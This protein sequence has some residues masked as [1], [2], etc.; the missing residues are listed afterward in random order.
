MRRDEEATYPKGTRLMEE[1]EKITLINKLIESQKEI[2]TQ[3]ERMPISNRSVAIQTKKN[4][5]EKKLVDLDN[6]IQ[7]FKRRKVFVLK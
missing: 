5:M 6:D 2:L 3:I 7:Y 1:R 4:E